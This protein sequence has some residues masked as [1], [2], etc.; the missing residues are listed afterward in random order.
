MAPPR[1]PLLDGDRD[2]PVSVHA[3]TGVALADLAATVADAV[4]RTASE[5][6][7]TVLVHAGHNDAQL[8]EGAPRVDPAAFRDAAGALDRRLDAHPAVDRHLFVGLVPLLPSD[9]PGAVPFADAQPARSLAYDDL[10]AWTVAEHVPLARPV[11]AW[12]DRTVDGVHPTGDGH[13]Y[14]ADRVAAA[15][16]G[17]GRTL[18]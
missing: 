11:S 5:P 2:E 7:L 17:D 10:L 9:R 13:G 3:R 8:R 18:D 12:R 15:L 14:V 6:S 4:A 16:H 1:P